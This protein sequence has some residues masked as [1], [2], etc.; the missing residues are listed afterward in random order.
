VNRVSYHQNVFDLLDMEPLPVSPEAVALIEACERRCGHR[1]PAALR[2][3]CAFAE[4]VPLRERAS[5]ALISLWIRYSTPDHPVPL[6]SIL[7]EFEQACDPNGVPPGFVC[8]LVENQA[9]ARWYA[10]I[11]GSDDPPVWVDN[12]SEDR[13]EWTRLVPFSDFL[14]HWFAHFGSED[15]LPLLRQ[16]YRA[17][18][19]LRAP[20][21]PALL[22]PHLD[23]LIDALD[24]RPRHERPGGPTTYTFSAPAASLR[25]ASDHRDVAG[26]HSAWWLHG[27]TA[28]ALE[29]LARR[30]RHVG[31]LA[32]A[33]RADTDAGRAVLERL[34]R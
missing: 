10:E 18:V 30:V 20:R 29:G 3:W 16:P 31:A 22:P 17:G 8:L 15:C 4:N 23:Q 24:E 19:W 1:L 7:D 34:G 26:G 32:E 27:E 11:D 13:E 33:L 2:E 12:D 25:V 9:C 14:F 21:E 6:A 5:S 28:E